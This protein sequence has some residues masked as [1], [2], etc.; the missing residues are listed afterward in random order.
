MLENEN[1][2]NFNKILKL[3]FT[4]NTIFFL[5]KSDWLVFKEKALNDQL[6]YNILVVSNKPTQS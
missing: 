6:K 2:Y 3:F 4:L 5:I 1:N